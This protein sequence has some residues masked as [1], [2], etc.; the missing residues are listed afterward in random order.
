EEELRR[1]QKAEAVGRLAG[2]IAHDFNN[3]LTAITGH[4][5][6]LAEMFPEGDAARADIDG[7][8]IAAARAARLTAQLLAFS[9]AQL[10]H[11]T[12]LDLREVVLD[13]RV[14]LRRLIGDQIR[15]ECLVADAP[16]MVHAD[17]AQ[18]EQVLI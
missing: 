11:P 6:F 13:M 16:V 5:E 15:L 12:D 1:A 14:M 8:R 9:R 2:G 10:M 18:I 7:I 4:A 3:V 17:R